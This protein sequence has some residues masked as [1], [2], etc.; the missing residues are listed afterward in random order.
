VICTPIVGQQ[1]GA[2][3]YGKEGTK[4]KTFGVKNLRHLGYLHFNTILNAMIHILSNI[5]DS[6]NLIAAYF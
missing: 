4:F 6:R 2:Y 3:F 5:L 1:G